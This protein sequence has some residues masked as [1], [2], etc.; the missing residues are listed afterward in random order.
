MI[1]AATHIARLV[2]AAGVPHLGI[3]LRQQVGLTQEQLAEKVEVD[4]S[5][6]QRIEKGTANPGIDVLTRLKTVLGV[7]WDEL[8]EPKG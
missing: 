2:R 8:M 3:R 7:S 6:I 5:Y 4:R 1:S